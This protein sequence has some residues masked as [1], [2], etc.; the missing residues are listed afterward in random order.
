MRH[1]LT[2][3]IVTF[4]SGWLTNAFSKKAV[5]LKYSLALTFFYHNLVRIHQTLRR[6]PAMKAGIA[7]HKWSIEEMVD[8]LPEATHPRR[9]KSN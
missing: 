9:E 3:S 1:T 5:M 7:D 4:K 8:L 6:T 2:P